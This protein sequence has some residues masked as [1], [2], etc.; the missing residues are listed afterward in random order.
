M[1]AFP[2][3]YIAHNLPLILLSG[4]GDDEEGV[5]EP[6]EGSGNLLQDG[7]FRIRTYIPSLTDPASRDLLQAF[8]GFNSTSDG[9]D[10]RSASTRGSLGAFKIKRIGRVGQTPHGMLYYVD[11]G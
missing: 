7:G 6:A 4:I 9:F 11:I 3:D 2:E 10:R 5:A 1:E 8:L